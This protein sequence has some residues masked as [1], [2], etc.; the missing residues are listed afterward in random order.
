M[1]PGATHIQH[2]DGTLLS[3]GNFNDE[4]RIALA[5]QLLTPQTGA[6]D[7][8]QANKKVLR[9]L[10]NG[11][12]LLLNR[13]PTL[14]KPSIMA[15]KA[16]ILTGQKTLRM[17]YVNC[18][19]YNADFDGDEM[20]VHFP[21]NE[22]GRAEAYAIAYTDN[23]YI[24]PTDGSPLRGLIQDHVVSGVL[25]TARDTLLTRDQYNQLVF[26][27]IPDSTRKIRLMPPCILKPKPM[28]SGKQV[29]RSDFGL[30][31]LCCRLTRAPSS[32]FPRC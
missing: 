30:Y 15:H 1:H 8:N 17:H 26:G 16:R 14:H 21:Q 18:D 24:V 25:L 28:W 10:R 11:D 19:T 13:Q 5:N 9:H 31:C 12:V 7:G 29:V 22:L 4:S 6:V 3:L 20:N 2:E 23:Q 27:C 32:S